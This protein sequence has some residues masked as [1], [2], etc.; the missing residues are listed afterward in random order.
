MATLTP[1]P[2]PT[3]GSRE[4]D[5]VQILDTFLTWVINTAQSLEDQRA[6]MQAQIDGLQ[7]QITAL[8]GAITSKTITANE[9]VTEA[10]YADLV[11]KNTVSSTTEYL[12]TG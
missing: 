5:A 2:R 4:S 7:T 3:L 10:G 11:A 1:P 9:Q 6:A 8:S 12:V